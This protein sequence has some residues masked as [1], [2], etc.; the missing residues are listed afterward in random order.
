MHICFLIT[1]KLNQFVDVQIFSFT[2]LA[3][4]FHGLLKVFDFLHFAGGNGVDH[5]K[6]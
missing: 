2:N 3:P 5:I 6:F 4:G 1:W